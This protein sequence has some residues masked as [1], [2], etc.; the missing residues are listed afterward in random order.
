MGRVS[1]EATVRLLVLRTSKSAR[2]RVIGATR[3][4]SR[5]RLAWHLVGPLQPRGDCRFWLWRIN[6]FGQLFRTRCT[7]EP[8]GTGAADERDRPILRS[9]FLWHS[10]TIPG[11]VGDLAVIPVALWR[12]NI[13]QFQ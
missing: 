5:H 13:S 1:S 11:V 7:R 10:L 9:K 2:S 8:N 6:R 3:N 4:R 12:C